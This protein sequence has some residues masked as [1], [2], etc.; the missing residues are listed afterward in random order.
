M[1]LKEHTIRTLECGWDNVV[2]IATHY[3]LD[4]CKIDSWWQ[5]DFP[6][7]FILPVMLTQ[8]PVQWVKKVKQPRYRPG[9]AQRVPGS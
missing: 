6:Q 1:R 5:Q 7:E 2:G 8:S 9:V 3:R 4:G